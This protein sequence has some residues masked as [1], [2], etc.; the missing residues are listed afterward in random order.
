MPPAHV[1]EP[2][3]A[4]A[5]AQD[6]H[7]IARDLH[8]LVIQRLFAAGMLLQ[9]VHSSGGMSLDVR[10]RLGQALEEIDA[11]IREIR[12]TIIV[13]DEPSEGPTTGVRERVMEEAARWAVLLGF[14]PSVR[15]TGPIDTHIPLHIVEDVIGALRESL[16]NV[17]RH[18]HARRVDVSVSASTEV[19]E[20]VVIDDGIGVPPSVT[21]PSGLM[22]LVSRARDLGGSCT[23]TRVD[24]VGGTQV[25]W[26]VP[27]S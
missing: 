24:H 19:V 8:D 23:I 18:A 15:L 16:A 20:L 10:E 4:K 13:L 12:Q 21:C 6:H 2:V 22:N 27:V 11:T 14:E 3:P 25:R 17:V 1:T 7:R 5:R 26:W 9:T